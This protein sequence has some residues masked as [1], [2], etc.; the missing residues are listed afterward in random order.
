MLIIDVIMSFH[1]LKWSL[2]SVMTV[3]GDFRWGDGG[4][5]HFLE[6]YFFWKTNLKS[7]YCKIL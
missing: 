6:P 3:M 2:K 7:K 4:W 1:C 5:R